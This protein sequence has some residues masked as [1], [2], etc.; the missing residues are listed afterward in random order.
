M[1]PMAELHWGSAKRA[2]RSLGSMLQQYGVSKATFVEVKPLC[3]NGVVAGVFATRA[4]G[5]SGLPG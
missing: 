4:V 2:L 5:S 3:Q 1:L